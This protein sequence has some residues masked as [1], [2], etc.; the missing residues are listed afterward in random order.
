MFGQLIFKIAICR[1]RLQLRQDIPDSG[2]E[3]PAHSDDSFLVTT[4]SLDSAV[5]LPAFRVFIGLDNSICY[6]N[7]QWF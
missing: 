6:L 5:T 3:H 4:A 7:Q 1:I 2:Q